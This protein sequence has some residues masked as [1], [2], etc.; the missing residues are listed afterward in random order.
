LRGQRAL[1]F[2]TL[3]GQ[4]ARIVKVMEMAS[5]SIVPVT[6]VTGQVLAH[7]TGTINTAEITSCVVFGMHPELS[8]A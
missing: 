2:Q 8:S 3:D 4:F 7:A 1:E 6:S 5:R